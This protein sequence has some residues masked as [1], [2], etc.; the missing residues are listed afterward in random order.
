MARVCASGG[1]W[2]FDILREQ[3]RRLVL[4]GE[5]ADFK[6]RVNS[7]A[8]YNAVTHMH[9]L[10]RLDR[11]VETNRGSTAGLSGIRLRFVDAHGPEPFIDTNGVHSSESTLWR[12]ALFHPFE[13]H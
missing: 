2:I 3:T 10:G 5:C 7:V 4:I 8:H 11:S 1:V 9:F 6:V 12:S 13:R